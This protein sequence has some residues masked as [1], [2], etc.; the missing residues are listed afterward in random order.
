[1]LS[2]FQERFKNRTS[3]MPSG[4]ISKILLEPLQARPELIKQISLEHINKLEKSPKPQKG[5]ISLLKNDSSNLKYQNNS[6]IMIKSDRRIKEG[7]I[8][9]N[10][11]A[12]PEA[13][14]SKYLDSSFEKLNKS[15]TRIEYKPYSMKDYQNIKIEKYLELGGLGPTS[16]G[17]DEWVKKK[18]LYDKRL[19]YSKEA[20]YRNATNM[21][22]VPFST[23]LNVDTSAR[24]R[25]IE[26]AKSIIRPP[27]KVELANKY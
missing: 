7:K 26:F 27:L 17:S 10:K 14:L 16:V 15:T 18:E 19:N 24:K 3:Q 25:A 22:L 13:K 8:V 5:I 9:P 23:K 21:H 2:P 1:M 4:G 6:K 12:S 11:L 20:N